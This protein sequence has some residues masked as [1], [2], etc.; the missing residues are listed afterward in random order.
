M[1]S[2]MKQVFFLC[3]ANYYRSR[4]AEHFFNHLA[5]ATGLNWQAQSRG[6]MVGYWGNVG[7]ISEF[8]VDAL[9]ERGVQLDAHHRH[10][11]P[12]TEADLL[13]V[14]LVVAVKEVEHR[15]LIKEQFAGWE[16]RVEYWDVDDLDC[17][18]PDV[19]L[20]YLEERVRDL[21]ARLQSDSKA[22]SAKVT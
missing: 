9:T 3:S 18:T 6:L 14:D 20:P 2:T 11:Q 21:V 16:D 7:P 10:P 17:A 12:L 19:A 22:D 8:T 1:E 13:H 4:F 5:S 15:P